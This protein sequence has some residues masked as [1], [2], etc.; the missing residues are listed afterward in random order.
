MAEKRYYWLKLKDDFFDE[1]Y[2]KALRKLPQGDSL[3]IVYLKMQLKTLKTDGV[4]RYENILPN[5]LAELAL[6]IDESEEV[7]GLALEAL[8]RFGV[9]EQLDNDDL[10]LVKMQELI[11]SEGSSAA[12]KREYRQRKKQELLQCDGQ[13]GLCADNVPTMC[14]LRHGEI[15]KIREDIDNREDTD[16]EAGQTAEILAW[17]FDRFYNA[18]PRKTSREKAFRVWQELNPTAETVE[19]IMKA[20]EVQRNCEQWKKENGRYIPYPENYLLGRRWEDDTAK[21]FS[22][23]DYYNAPGN[24]SII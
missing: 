11:G 10:L 2:I 15:E 20:V 23:D 13:N 19:K 17:G 1:K 7:T 3:V 5:C 12:R 16:T 18:Y 9:I 24:D 6:A 14:G 4:F 21:P 22:L 8:V